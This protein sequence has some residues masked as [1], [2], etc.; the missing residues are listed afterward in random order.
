MDMYLDRA[1]H[2][3]V[4]YPEN[5]YMTVSR[6]RNII[7]VTNEPHKAVVINDGPYWYS[8]GVIDIIGDWLVNAV[9]QSQSLAGR[10]KIQEQGSLFTMTNIYFQQELPL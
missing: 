2:K 6:Y 5:I 4:S 7:A 9:R 8:P 1:C 3:T 10:K